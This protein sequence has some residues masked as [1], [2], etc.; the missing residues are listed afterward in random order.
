MKTKAI[1]FGGLAFFLM[2]A[3]HG[4]AQETHTRFFRD[5]TL[6]SGLHIQRW[7]GEGD[8]SIRE[9]SIPLVFI[10]PVGKRL[11]LDLVTGSGFAALDRG[12]SSSL[13]GLTD[14][15]IRA[16]YIVGEEVALLT[17]GLSTPTGKTELD[18]EEQ[19]VSSFLSQNALRFRTPNFGQ[20][21]DTNVGVATA[22]KIGE[23]VF[24]LG[25]GYL[26]KGEFTPRV[27]GPKYTPGNELSLTAGLDRKV[28]DGDGKVT[29]DVSYTL[30]GEDEQ[31]G[32]K[33]FQSGNKIL[34]QGLGIFEAGGMDWR[35]HLIERSK[36]KNTSYAGP[37]STEFSN[38]NQ[39]E[40]GLSILKSRSPSLGLRGL[41]DL[42]LYGDN[43][44]DRGEA[45]IFG[46]GPGI[47]YKLSPGRFIDLS[48]KYARGSID[49]ATVNGIDISG[50]I[51]IRM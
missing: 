46:I 32:S 31:D 10:L 48:L 44:F 11:S 50:S 47:R 29:L 23:I 13:N 14:T 15:K 33:A 22:K 51:W 28:M 37:S 40:V 6:G 42:K 5:V 38:G 25:A 43:E 18:A 45:T 8:L 30:Y 16:S 20:G 1:L 17:I 49:A 2:T 21:L 35:V 4:Q 41:V 7:S 3:N 36:G 27:G 9:F 12:T 39:F 19:E 34:V 24:G 26:V